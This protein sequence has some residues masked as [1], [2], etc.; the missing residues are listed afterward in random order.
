MPWEE[1][2]HIMIES[3]NYYYRYNLDKAALTPSAVVIEEKVAAEHKTKRAKHKNESFI[4]RI[5]HKAASL[6]KV[7]NISSR[8]LLYN[9]VITS[10]WTRLLTHSFL[11]GYT[12][13]VLW[14]TH[15]TASVLCNIR[16]S[17]TG[18][19]FSEP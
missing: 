17:G 13:Y 9:Y 10:S 3:N 12:L 2:L 8:N 6:I 19:A 14:P 4:T 5:F 1:A 7:M 15:H 18:G 11:I 16:N